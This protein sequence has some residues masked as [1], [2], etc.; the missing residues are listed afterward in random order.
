MTLLN[1]VKT[2]IDEPG[3]S[4]FW[5]LQQVY[6]AIN[7]S[8]IEV[9]GSG[10]YEITTATITATASTTF[11]TLPTS[12]MTPKF[13]L[14]TNN[15]EI[16]KTTFADLEREGPG[17]GTATGTAP[18]AF[19]DVDIN[20]IQIYPI[21]GS[22]VEYRIVGVPYPTEVTLGVEDFTQEEN[23]AL[24]AKF[25]AGSIL[26]DA[27]RP[28]L[29]EAYRLEGEQLMPMALRQW[30]NQQSHKIATLRIGNEVDAR[31]RGS[32]DIIRSL[33]GLM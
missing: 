26:M 3:A 11:I 24:V 28:D 33:G 9:L 16:P 32:M 19:I 25:Y 12:I 10:Q 15:S 8:S 17:W 4:K 22:A 21:V 27:T 18:I 31:R 23:F 13:V 29:S 2:I 7:E 5:P 6:D 30:R 14:N 20:T 1:Q